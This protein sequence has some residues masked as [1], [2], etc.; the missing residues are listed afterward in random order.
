MYLSTSTVLD[1]NPDTELYLLNNKL[2]FGFK[3][4]VHL[5]SITFNTLLYAALFSKKLFST[6]LNIDSHSAF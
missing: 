4:V 2:A 1:P 5:Y 6:H 3:L